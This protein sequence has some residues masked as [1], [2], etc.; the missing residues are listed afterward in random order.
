MSN[1]VVHTTFKPHEFA[2]KVFIFQV[3]GKEKDILSDNAVKIGSISTRQVEVQGNIVS[4]YKHFNR[5][6][7]VG[8][9]IFTEF[10]VDDGTGLLTCNVWKM[11]E[12]EFP[13]DYE[14][15]DL[16]T[17]QGKLASFSQEIR[18]NVTNIRKE[19]DV[20]AEILQWLRVIK[21]NSKHYNKK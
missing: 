6:S 5:T 4:V 13:I 2:A 7:Y 17:I 3:L 1:V 18:L 14:L 9:L 21:L 16:I 15:G 8:N 11:G 20:N 19:D 10:E 12:R